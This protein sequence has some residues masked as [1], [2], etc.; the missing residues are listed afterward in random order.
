MPEWLSLLQSDLK[1]WL[2]HLELSDMTRPVLFGFLGILLLLPL[3]GVDR[4]DY[5]AGLDF[6]AF[7]A[8]ATVILLFALP[9]SFGTQTSDWGTL[10]TT[11]FVVAVLGA[12]RWVIGANRFKLVPAKAMIPKKGKG[13]G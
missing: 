1:I 3:K 4:R 8:A 9:Q 2:T 6:I 11:L 13:N 12:A 7:L 10:L 5:F